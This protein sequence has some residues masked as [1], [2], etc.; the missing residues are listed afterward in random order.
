MPAADSRAL[1]IRRRVI[2]AAK[3]VYKELG[4]GWREDVY[5]EALAAEL[6]PLQAVCEICQPVV[7]KGNTLPHVSVRWDMLV[8]GTVL[9]ELKAVR[10]K[11]S[12]SAIRQ[13]MRYNASGK[14]LTLAVNFPDRPRA[15]V[16]VGY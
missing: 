2:S 14:Y 5:R 6:A 8:E 4:W 10:S 7:Y 12:H 16:E 15:A 13:A 1:A 9:V 3:S 11:L